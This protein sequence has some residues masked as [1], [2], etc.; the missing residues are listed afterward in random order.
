MT[1]EGWWS[2][3]LGGGGAT[4]QRKK[5]SFMG[6]VRDILVCFIQVSLLVLVLKSNKSKLFCK[7]IQTWNWIRFFVLIRV[8]SWI[9]V[10]V[11]LYRKLNID[12]RN[13]WLSKKPDIQNRRVFQ[14]F[15]NLKFHVR[16]CKIYFL[17]E[18][19]DF[20]IAIFASWWFQPLWKIWVKMG[21]FPQV[22]VKIKNIWNH[23]P[24]K[25]YFP[26]EQVDFSRLPSLLYLRRISGF[27]RPGPVERNIGGSFWIAR[28]LETPSDGP[29]VGS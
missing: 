28:N 15:S 29:R 10:L 3:R 2:K 17:W 8:P 12:N 22:G 27:Q 13:H 1:V 26:C 11:F 4:K 6:H 9:A 14:V 19:V 21:S 23:H 20:S 25:V 24:G 16:N 7:K 5:P 18:Q